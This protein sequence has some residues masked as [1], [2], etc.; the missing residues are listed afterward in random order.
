MK[1][2]REELIK[3]IKSDKKLMKIIAIEEIEKQIREINI[4]IVM[5][6]TKKIKLEGDLLKV[7][8]GG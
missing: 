7:K 4:Q 3:E 6:Q 5:L 2:D 1:L 8:Y